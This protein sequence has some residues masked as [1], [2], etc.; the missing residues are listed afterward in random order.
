MAK[1][2][3]IR[4][5]FTSPIGKAI[6][7]KLNEADYHYKKQGQYQITLR[8]PDAEA[9]PFI[10]SMEEFMAKHRETVLDEADLYEGDEVKDASTPWKPA[11]DKVKDEE[12][13][14]KRKVPVPGFT[15]IT[16]KC[17]ASYQK[18][19]PATHEKSTVHV[20]PA[21]IDLYGKNID[22]AKTFIRGG[23]VCVVGGQASPFYT[24]MAGFGVSLRMEAVQVRELSSGVNATDFFQVEEDPDAVTEAAVAAHGSDE[25]EDDFS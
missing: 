18:E 24:A 15:D 14:K 3:F 9:E 13:G 17:N 2:K 12:T 20:R 8:I 10:A 22:P 25:D 19:D 5:K 11:V 7:P 4:K 23:S 21:L 16:F 6:W 1:R